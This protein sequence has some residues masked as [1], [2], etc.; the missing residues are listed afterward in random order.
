[1]CTQWKKGNNLLLRFGLLPDIYGAEDESAWIQ[2]NRYLWN[3]YRL[4]VT[5]IE[6]E[7]FEGF[8]VTPSVYTTLSDI[9]RIYDA[10]KI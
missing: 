6:H 9:N 4:I 8:L 10:W 2:M 7:E 5:P 3:K 1:L